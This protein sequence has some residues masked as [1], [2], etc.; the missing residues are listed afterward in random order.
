MCSES[1]KA[2]AVFNKTKKNKNINFLQNNSLGIQHTYSN[3]FSI[4]QISSFDI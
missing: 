1:M 4:G 2:D 3:K